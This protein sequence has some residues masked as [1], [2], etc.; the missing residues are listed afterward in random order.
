MK[1]C[2]FKL[3]VLL[4][5]SAPAVAQ[6]VSGRVT[7]SA[8]GN[9]LP[10]VSVLIKGTTTGTTTDTDGRYSL[11]VPDPSSSV[12]LFSFIGFATQEV[13]VGGRTSFDVLLKEDAAQLEEVIVTA[14]GIKRSERTLSYSA[15]QINGDK[16]A[17]AR[18]GNILNNLSGKLPGIVVAPTGS[19]LGGSTRITIR[20]NSFLDGSGQPLIVVDGVPI[21]NMGAKTDDVWGNRQIDYGNGLNDINMDDV[22][23]ISVLKGPAASALYGSRAGSGVIMIT[24]KSAKKG[25]SGATFNSNTVVEMARPYLEMQNRY[26]Q[27]SNGVFDATAANS[28][29]P[30]MNGQT[31]TDWTGET[32]PLVAGN[33]DIRDFLK[34]G[35]STTNSIELFSSDD[36]KNVRAS[37]GYNHA[38]GIFPGSNIKKIT[39]AVKAGTKLGKSFYTEFSMNYNNTKGANRIKLTRDPDNP[40]Y[41]YTIMPR[42]VSFTDLE[43]HVRNEETYAP[44]RWNSNGGV[45][46]NPYFTTNYNTNEDVR[47]RLIGYGKVMYSVGDKFTFHVRYGLDHY[48]LRRRDQLGT[49]VPYWFTSGDVK[50]TAISSTETNIELLGQLTKLQLASGLT[51][52]LSAGANFMAANNYTTNANANGLVVPDF[53][54]INNSA[55][56]DASEYIYQRRMNS[57][58]GTA[59][60]S[61][62]EYLFLDLTGRNDW[63]STLPPDNMSYPYYSAGLSWIISDS[64]ESMPG[65]L[66]YAKVRGSYATVGKDTEPYRLHLTNTIG[67]NGATAPNTKP[68]PNLK[69]ELLKSTEFGADVNLFNNRIKF[70]YTYYQ[71]NG[72]R[73][74]FPMLVNPA[75]EGFVFNIINAGNIQNNGHEMSLNFGIVET[76]NFSADLGVNWSTND[77]KIVELT[78]TQDTQLLGDG[79]VQVVAKEG[80]SFGDIYGYTFMRDGNGN[81][82]LNADGQFQ[83]SND[84]VKLGNFMP[85][86]NA[87]ITGAVS[88]GTAGLGRISFTVLFDYMKGGDVYSFTNAQAAGA[89]TSE[90]TAEN[91]R[92][93]YTI[94]GVKATGEAATG[95]MTA[96]QYW[97]KLATIDSEWVY[98]K[99]EM[100]LRELTLGYSLPSSVLKNTRI[101]G[102]SLSLVGRNLAT[103]GSKLNGVPPFAYTTSNQQG[104]EAF[105][106]PRT[107]TLGFNLKVQF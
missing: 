59:Q 40:Y 32:K 76:E 53:Y 91:N 4:L 27:G 92:G 48:D 49:G 107:A 67:P 62:K 86:W 14:L 56:R 29:G 102:A 8:N 33:N 13:A 77:N 43:N 70:G 11:N 41:S 21:D 72:T 47:D 96:E 106:S 36:V 12:L 63:S 5:A 84:R 44:L 64:F 2:L 80:G 82:I 95:T 7:D 17:T 45:I 9:A 30:E 54:S 28:W 26:A 37:V 60:L 99:S 90:V 78:E 50:Q 68:N 24:T 79:L 18:E 31:V 101:K 1:K 57:V 34:T 3:L 55:N 38:D 104:A 93:N 100:N 66:S 23:N 85:D 25:T 83:R 16:L 98:D 58:L 22:E 35:F 81:L 87:G 69:N 10:G 88:Y 52:G 71:N 19:G 6:T 105:S 42:S 51:L 89:G 74:I 103:F 46:L 75:E 73:Q 97:S 94:T 15:A 65:W 39:A 61:Y 20:G